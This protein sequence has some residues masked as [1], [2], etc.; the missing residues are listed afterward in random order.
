MA[1]DLNKEILVC[2]R[3]GDP[4]P[5]VI[6]HRHVSVGYPELTRQGCLGGHVH[7][8]DIREC[9]KVPDL[10]LGLESR[11]PCLEIDT[12]E[13]YLDPEPGAKITKKAPQRGIKRGGDMD[14]VME[15]EGGDICELDEIFRNEEGPGW[16]PCGERTDRGDPDDMVRPQEP[17]CLD[18]CPVINPMRGGRAVRPMPGDN[19]GSAVMRRENRDHAKIRLD[20]GPGQ[21]RDNR[22][23]EEVRTAN[24]AEGGHGFHI[25]EET[26]V[27]KLGPEVENSEL[28][29]VPDP[30]PGTDDLACGEKQNDDLRGAEP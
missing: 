11:S 3:P 15:V 21:V 6:N 1:P 14:P 19:M 12:T 25:S 30:G 9:G 18:I 17:E 27:R 23:S 20:R 29:I 7:T 13:M 4:I 28:Y 2:D 10:C 16:D 24:D 5:P 22:G 26:K 8:H